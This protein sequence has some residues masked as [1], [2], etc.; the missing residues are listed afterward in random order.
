MHDFYGSSLFYGKSAL[1]VITSTGSHNIQVYYS[2]PNVYNIY[3]T[4]NTLFKKWNKYEKSSIK[5]SVIGSI[6]Y[7][8]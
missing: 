4:D 3:L 2:C 6:Q 5:F 8:F 1:L 7:I